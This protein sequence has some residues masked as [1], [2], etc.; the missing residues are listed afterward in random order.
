[1]PPP[2]TLPQSS[3]S[4]SSAAIHPPPSR[5]SNT[6]VPTPTSKEIEAVIQAATASRAAGPPPG[7]DT[8]TQLFVGNLPYRVRWQDLK[9]LFRKAGTVLRADVSLGPDNRSRGYGT[10]LLATAEDAGRAIDMFN[11]FSW[12]NRILEV[13][14]DRLPPEYDI[15]VPL[16]SPF[17]SISFP[18]SHTS[19]P[20]PSS[21]SNPGFTLS[22]TQSISTDLLG[23][24]TLST[25]ASMPTLNA[26]LGPG[27]PPQ[28]PT[29]PAAPQVS[30]ISLSRS[31]SRNGTHLPTSPT[32]SLGR[33]VFVGNLPFQ[34]Q[35]QD[36]KDM[37]RQIGPVVRADVA[38]GADGRSRGYDYNSRILKVYHDKFT[39]AGSTSPPPFSAT[40][41]HQHSS[42]IGANPHHLAPSHVH[43]QSS[44]YLFHSQPTSP[45]D[46]F[47]PA[48]PQ[49]VV[50]QYLAA[51]K[52]IV[53]DLP[54]QPE[55]A[56]EPPLPSSSSR[57]SMSQDLPTTAISRPSTASSASNRALD[58]PSYI[59]LGFPSLYQ[60]PPSTRSST[61]ASFDSFTRSHSSASN[62]TSEQ[63]QTPS[64][65]AASPATANHPG[66]ISIPPPPTNFSTQS[67][68]FS[69]LARGL[70][71]MT[72]SMPGFTF[73]PQVST[74]PGLH[75]H[76]LSPGIGPA[77][78]PFYRAGSFHPA[79]G[80]PTARAANSMMSMGMFAMQTPP[81][82]HPLTPGHPVLTPGPRFNPAD[83]PMMVNRTHPL[84][85]G[86]PIAGRPWP[87]NAS[88]I[89]PS[90]SNTT[91]YAGGL[92]IVNGVEEP[93]DYF[94]PIDSDPKE[95]QEYFP[96]VVGHEGLK[97]S[98]F[99]T[100]DPDG[101]RS[102]PN[103]EADTATTTTTA[104]DSVAPSSEPTVLPRL[105][106]EDMVLDINN[107][108]LFGLPSPGSG[109]RASWAEA[110]SRRLTAMT[111]A[112]A[113]SR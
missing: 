40:A 49:H 9:D 74:P 5:S 42:F 67:T 39:Q 48:L 6:P 13:R 73:H 82:A 96:A 92:S 33:S 36:L 24:L 43:N 84:S 15:N 22:A 57:A 64:K 10:V 101:T 8:R 29:F 61:D 107:P 20:I 4:S 85:P 2:Q 98:D 34:C 91:P 3:R 16:P 69:P 51:A 68:L 100:I 46:A 25:A 37:F 32:Q 35:W 77:S 94:P 111:Q 104:T 109:R 71:P 45:F 72:P 110:G 103:S 86:H 65:K 26:A 30:T 113:D 31:A 7:R 28:L 53:S 17:N 55:R 11:G 56:T 81:I 12:Q 23:G 80:A 76:F 106:K 63:P 52:D 41:L 19:L 93:G 102:A 108:G 62:P 14:P 60:P 95:P 83:S 50:E 58:E 27:S 97:S 44:A 90:N 18:H 87:S 59:K 112:D 78:P 38:I 70:P 88:D 89:S 47:P 66:P 105:G 75:P 1:M 79:P 21:L 54:L 99:E